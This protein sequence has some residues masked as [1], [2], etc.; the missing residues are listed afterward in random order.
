MS[1]NSN[2]MNPRDCLLKS[3]ASCQHKWL[4]MEKNQF[5]RKLTKLTENTRV[6][7]GYHWWTRFRG[8]SSHRTV[9]HI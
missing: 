4:P 7:K 2:V 9:F 6:R 1:I 5:C 3:K 8:N